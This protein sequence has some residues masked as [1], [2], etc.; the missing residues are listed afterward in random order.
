MALSQPGQIVCKTISLKQIKN[1]NKKKSAIKKK[2]PITAKKKKKKN[3]L[4][5][6]WT[7]ATRSRKQKR[8]YTL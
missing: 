5:L 7:R 4:P 3:Q 6:N 1:N 8:I 2:N